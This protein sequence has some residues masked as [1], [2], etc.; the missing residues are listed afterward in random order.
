MVAVWAFWMFLGFVIE[1][2]LLIRFLPGPKY[3]RTRYAIQFVVG[4]VVG[5]PLI[6]THGLLF[7]VAVVALIVIASLVLAF[8]ERM[9]LL[10]VLG[11]DERVDEELRKI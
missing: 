11:S 10:R 8:Y 3:T 4:A 6:L 1:S 2:G 7:S 9:L 5:V